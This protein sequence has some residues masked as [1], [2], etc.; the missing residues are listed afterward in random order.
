[1]ISTEP[2][3]RRNDLDWLRVF[4][5]GLLIYFHTAAVFYQGS[6]GEFYVTNAAKSS[7]MNF[8]ILGVH[9]WHMPLFFFLAGAATWFSLKKRSIPQYLNERVQRLLIPFIFGTL[10]FV[11]PQVY[12]HLLQ[13]SRF[14]GSYFKFYPQFFNGIR[15]NGNFEWAHLWFVVYLFV[16]SIVALPIITYSNKVLNEI[17]RSRLIQSLENNS[18][19]FLLALPLS[20]VEAIFRPKWLGF[21][22]LYDDWANVLLY[23]LYFIYGY[24]LGANSHFEAMLD[25]ASNWILLSAIA[26]MTFLA[27]LWIRNAVPSQGYSVL[28]MSYQAFRGL[29]SWLWVLALL[30]L[31][32]RYFRF[33]NSVLNYA[34]EAAYPFYILHQT[35]IVAV[36]FYV[37]QLNAGITAKFLLISTVGLSLTLMIYEL[38]VRRIP[39]LRSLLGMK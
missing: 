34:S 36:A 22:N 18:A 9:Q 13:Q 15:P 25:R 1:M 6:L 30:S 16:L 23:L 26:S 10:V 5:V 21:Q 38:F 2:N 19:I 29:N 27:I 11:P 24:F 37:V 12:F 8:F 17:W 28:Y 32:Q 20:L 39:V 35:I 14:E 3:K 7:V 4:A 31:G 33:R